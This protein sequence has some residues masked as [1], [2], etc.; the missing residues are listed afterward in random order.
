MDVM[1][2][3]LAC[4]YLESPRTYVCVDVDENGPQLEFAR[5]LDLLE[6][7][8]RY[9]NSP[10]QLELLINFKETPHL[11]SPIIDILPP[12]E[13]VPFFPSVDPSGD[14][15]SESVT[16]F[17][18]PPPIFTFCTNSSVLKIPHLHM[19]SLITAWITVST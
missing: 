8:N 17:P 3:E 11:D 16:G 10:K 1:F 18:S 19:S 12:P 9:I 6:E 2:S 4:T 13:L 5:E 7:L 14:T 15:E